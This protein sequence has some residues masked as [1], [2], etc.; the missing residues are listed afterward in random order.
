MDRNR[1]QVMQKAIKACNFFFF[2]KLLSL[3]ICVTLVR[4]SIT[5][6]SNLYDNEAFKSQASWGRLKMKPNKIHK[7]EPQKKKQKR[8]AI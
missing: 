4:V 8:R 5:V 1:Q 2:L 6:Q 3:A 7:K